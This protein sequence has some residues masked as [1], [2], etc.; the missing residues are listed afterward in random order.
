[1]IKDT[2]AFIFGTIIAIAV[3]IGIGFGINYL[4][5]LSYSFFAPKYEDARRNV[6]ENTQSFVDWKNQEIDKYYM[7][8][9]RSDSDKEKKAISS[10]LI[11]S[12][13]WVDEEKLGYTEK[14]YLNEMKNYK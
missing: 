11:H 13:A 8:F 14:L 2:L 3:V 4:N 5:L 12:L 6:F 9:S 1:M 7:E 10:V